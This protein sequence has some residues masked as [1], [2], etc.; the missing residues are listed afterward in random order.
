MD[1]I[2]KLDAYARLVQL[3]YDQ[4]FVEFGNRHYAR[5]ELV[6][7]DIFGNKS[8]T[9]SN[10]ATLTAGDFVVVCMAEQFG[11]ISKWPALAHAYLF[12]E[13]RKAVQS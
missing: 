8:W 12:H 1:T 2:I 5:N 9:R 7:F 6:P 4:I 3:E 11:Q 10:L 13:V